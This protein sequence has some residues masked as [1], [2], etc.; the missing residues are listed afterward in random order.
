MSSYDGRL[1]LSD[2]PHRSGAAPSIGRDL[3]NRLQFERY[4]S[5]VEAEVNGCTRMALCEP[6]PHQTHA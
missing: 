1:L 6:D 4:R 2:A 5:L 3:E